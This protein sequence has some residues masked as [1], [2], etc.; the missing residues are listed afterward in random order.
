MPRPRSYREN[1]MTVELYAFDCG[2]L[3]MPLGMLLA[4]EHGLMTVP[5]PAFLIKHARGNVLFDSGLH[6]QLLHDAPAYLGEKLNAVFGVHYRGD[7]AIA[8]CLERVDIDVTGISHLVN[9]HL[10]FDHCGGNCRIPNAAVVVQKKEWEWATKSEPELGYYRTD[11]VTGQ[12][13]RTVDGEY[14]IFGDGSVVCIPTYGHTPGHQS[15][16]VQTAS[17]EFVLTGDACYLRRTLE[18]LHLPTILFDREQA[19]ASL[20]KLR[21]LQSRG[22]RIIFGHDPTTWEEVVRAPAR[23][24]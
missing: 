15:L 4:G 6:E 17:G 7:E 3:T 10:H 24:G 9:S 1:V 20:H 11:Y 16:K 19:I 18:Q 21:A 5:V 13:V 12:D 22:A 14:D 8:A 23:L 2:H